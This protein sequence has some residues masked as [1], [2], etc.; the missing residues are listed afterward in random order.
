MSDM[1]RPRSLPPAADHQQHDTLLVAQFVAG[2]PLEPER[3]AEARHVLASCAA[4]AAL[5]ADLPAISRAVAQEPV[6]PRRRDFRLTPEQAA[7]LRGNVLTR[8][9]RRLSLP[10]SRAFQP[11]AAG[12]LSIGLL[13]MVAGYAWPEDGS[14]QLQAG[15][16][17]VDRSTPASSVPAASA[18]PAEEPAVPLA[19]P[20]G[21]SMALEGAEGLMEESDFADTLTESQA[22][23]SEG[24]KQRSIADDVPAEVAREP[25]AMQ[26]LPKAELEDGEAALGAAADA[27]EETVGDA[28][29]RSAASSVELFAD[30]SEDDSVEAVDTTGTE[31]IVTVA[32]ADAAM[33]DDESGLQQLIIVLGLALALGGAGLLFLGWLARRARDPLAP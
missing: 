18:R 10:R 32:D 14:L 4:C 31:T 25:D 15:T 29:T 17:L 23:L 6:P 1:S 27:V 12:V 13:F 9:M 11:A 24:A 16:D 22:G 19:A 2:D 7:D 21:A 30:A 3:Q 8:F 20:D 33:A 26:S 28:T 5:A